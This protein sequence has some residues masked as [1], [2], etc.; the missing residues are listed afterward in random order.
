[1]TI[2]MKKADIQKY[3]ERLKELKIEGELVAKLEQPTTKNPNLLTIRDS[4]R[5]NNFY[6][7][8]ENNLMNL[9]GIENPH[10]KNFKKI[11]ETEKLFYS[12]IVLS[13]CGIIQSIL[14]DYEKGTLYKFDFLISG[15]IFDSILE[16]ATELN[17]NNFKDA[18]AVMV[19]TVVESSLKK[20]AISNEINPKNTAA[21]LNTKLKDKNIYDKVQHSE[22]QSWLHLGNYAAHGEFDKYDKSKISKLIDDVKIFI[23]EHFNN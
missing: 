23:T 2:I 15:N 10:Y 12:N 8:V 4:F 7:S 16:Q 6:S 3:I 22:I 14:T 1:M 5:L 19:R 21:N 17:E 20:L 18:A 11:Q 9:L 13:V